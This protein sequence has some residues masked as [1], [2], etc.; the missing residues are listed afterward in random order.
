MVTGVSD[1]MGTVYFGRE[2]REFSAAV[3]LKNK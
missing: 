3:L 1:K 2:I